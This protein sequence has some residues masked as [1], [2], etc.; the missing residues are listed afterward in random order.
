MPIQVALEERVGPRLAPERLPAVPAQ[1]VPQ[2]F[3]TAAGKG[4]RGARQDVAQE[5]FERAGPALRAMLAAVDTKRLNET[6]GVACD[7]LLGMGTHRVILRA[8]ARNRTLG[9][10]LLSNLFRRMPRI[11]RR[12]AE[13]VT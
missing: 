7:D 5:L 4:P 11:R 12:S 9:E 3:V 6:L 8:A 1:H 2:V 10:P 13:D